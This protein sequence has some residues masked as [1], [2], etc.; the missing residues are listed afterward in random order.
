MENPACAPAVN[1]LGV[2]L[3]KRADGIVGKCNEIRRGPSAGSRRIASLRDQTR[4]QTR[5]ANSAD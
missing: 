2:M 5:D 3:E 4:R 1:A